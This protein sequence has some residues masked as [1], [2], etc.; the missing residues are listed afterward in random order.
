[1]MSFTHKHRGLR[2]RRLSRSNQSSPARPLP[3]RKVP[4]SIPAALLGAAVLA[5]LSAGC[6]N[7]PTGNRLAEHFP[8]T[9]KFVKFMKHDPYVKPEPPDPPI[10]VDGAM[11]ERQWPQSE[12]KWA[13]AKM[14][15][16]PTRFPYNLDV[17]ERPCPNSRLMDTFLFACQFFQLPFTYIGDR[18]FKTVLYTSRVKY[19]PTYEAMP[20]LPPSPEPSKVETAGEVSMPPDTVPSIESTTAPTTVPSEK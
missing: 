13:N 1:M 10:V 14:V 5:G 20:A 8:N 3:G 12:A 15:G 18:P 11:L 2:A 9:A 17:T 6:Q 19:N 16:W 7:S 4:R